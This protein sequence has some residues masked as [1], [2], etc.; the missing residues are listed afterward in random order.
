MRLLASVADLD[1]VPVALAAG[2][3]ILDLKD[4]RHGAL[5]AWTLEALREAV[6]AFGGQRPLSATTGDLPMRP[7]TVLAA[8]RATAATGVDYVKVGFFAGGD[9]IGCAA[10]LGEVEG[11]VIAVLMADQEQDPDLVERIADAGLAGVMLDTADKRGGGLLAHRDLGQLRRFADR[12]RARGLL[13]GLA[14]SLTVADVARLAPIE[15]DYLG[16]RGA[17]CA[18]GRA[19]LLDPAACAALRQA[20]DAAASR[21]TATAGAAVSIDAAA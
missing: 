3:D 21:A 14:G 4:P 11:L 13:T 19:G 15:P 12:A 16:F 5:G 6:A 8:T 18:G 1:E 2:A 9:P 10:A 20:V 17:L 7:E